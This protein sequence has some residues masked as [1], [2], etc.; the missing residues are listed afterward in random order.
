MNSIKLSF[1]QFIHSDGKI[2]EVTHSQKQLRQFLNWFQTANTRVLM[3]Q[4]RDKLVVVNHLI[5]H[6]HMKRINYSDWQKTKTQEK[7][8]L[9][10]QFCQSWMTKAIKIVIFRFHGT[11]MVMLLS[12]NKK[13]T[14]KWH[15]A[16]TDKDHCK[17]WVTVTYSSKFNGTT[18]KC[19]L[20][21]Q[22]TDGNGS[23][24]MTT[25]Q[26]M[27]IHQV[28]DIYYFNFLTSNE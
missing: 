2:V 22:W 24:T 15:R 16:Q 9:K 17:F 7:S 20:R 11:K 21:K 25:V 12:G 3:S 4:W 26:C 8:I 1:L 6:I 10:E 28:D 19:N 27:L 5:L 13:T 23:D 14:T 18:G